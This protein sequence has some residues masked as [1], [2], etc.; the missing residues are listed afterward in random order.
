MPSVTTRL[1]GLMS[2]ALLVSGWGMLEVYSRARGPLGRQHGAAAAASAAMS[3]THSVAAVGRSPTCTPRSS[4]AEALERVLVGHVVAREQH[5]RRA[6]ALA[7]LRDRGVL[8]L[9]PEGVLDDVVA[10]PAS[11]VRRLGLRRSRRRRGSPRRRVGGRR[12]GACARRIRRSSARSTRR[13]DARSPARRARA[14]RRAARASPGVVAVHDGA[15]AGDPELGAVRAGEQDRRVVGCSAMTRRSAR[16]RPDTSATMVS[17]AATSASTRRRA[18]RAASGRPSARPRAAT[19]VP[20]KS[21]ATSRRSD[22]ATRAIAA[23][24]SSVGCRSCVTPGSARLA[25]PDAVERRE[26]VDCDQSATSCSSTRRAERPHPPALLGR[27]HLD[28][29]A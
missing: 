12:P 2:I 1:R 23:P 14:A 18:R 9:V 3:G 21:S 28:R 15:L 20:S 22:A 26:E 5:G 10:G 4:G 19:S 24:A 27:R 17:G 6:R 16:L 8:A 25:V 11:P 29:R 7:Q 13:R